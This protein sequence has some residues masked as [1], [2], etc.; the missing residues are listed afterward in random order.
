[1]I[2]EYVTAAVVA[3]GDVLVFLLCEQKLVVGDAAV[4]LV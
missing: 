1:M 2:R 4:A 3:P